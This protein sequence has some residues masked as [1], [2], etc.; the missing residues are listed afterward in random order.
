[1]GGS[2]E[3]G[4][5]VVFLEERLAGDGE[6]RVFLSEALRENSTFV[7]WR[8]PSSRFLR[9]GG[10]RRWWQRQSRNGVRSAPPH[11]LGFARE[12]ER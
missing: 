5:V 1:M 11:D 2:Y 9:R 12:A 8:R 4:I 6:K 10:R 7:D 3:F